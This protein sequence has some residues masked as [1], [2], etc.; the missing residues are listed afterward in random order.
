[1]TLWVRQLQTQSLVMLKLICKWPFTMWASFCTAMQ[2]KGADSY[3][4]IND[5]NSKTDLGTYY[6]M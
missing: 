4:A 3:H 5:D 6:I 1:M 2:S